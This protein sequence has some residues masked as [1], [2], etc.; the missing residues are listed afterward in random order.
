MK[1]KTV[2]W[3]DKGFKFSLHI[4]D[5][6]DYFKVR[7]YGVSFVGPDNNMRAVILFF[8][9]HHKTWAIHEQQ[10]VGRFERLN[11]R[12]K[13]RAPQAVRDFFRKIGYPTKAV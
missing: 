9:Y 12:E 2:Q 8:D 1:Y 5:R 11:L 3:E 7:Q 10:L 6:P 4:L 13:E